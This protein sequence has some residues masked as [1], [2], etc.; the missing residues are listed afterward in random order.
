MLTDPQKF[1]EVAGAEVE[2]AR[3]SAG[4][5][6]SVYATSDGLTKLTISTQETSSNRKRHVL[7]IDCTKIATDTYDE[8]RKM[9]T[10]ISTYVVIDRPQNGFT[11]EEAKKLVEGVVGLLSASTYSVTKKLIGGES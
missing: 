4:D 9:D 8:S 1:K 6:K 10:S 2:A 11:A 7:R 3:V 5:F